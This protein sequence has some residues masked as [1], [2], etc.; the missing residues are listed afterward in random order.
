[1]FLSIGGEGP[2]DP[3]WMENGAWIQY[4]QDHNAFLFMVEHRFYGKTHPTGSALHAV[5]FFKVFGRKFQCE[6]FELCVSS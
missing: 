5:C 2:A 6:K 1:M 3:V 4:A